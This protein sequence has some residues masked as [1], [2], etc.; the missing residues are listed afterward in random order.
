MLVGILKPEWDEAATRGA[1][2][3]DAA[4]KACE[5]NLSLYEAQAG[6]AISRPRTKIAIGTRWEPTDVNAVIRQPWGPSAAI[7][8]SSHS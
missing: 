6:E 7:T 5:K 3:W 8:A 4:W 1:D 2:V